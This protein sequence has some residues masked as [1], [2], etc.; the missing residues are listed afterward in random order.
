M[1]R[2]IILLGICIILGHSQTSQDDYVQM[3]IPGY[4]HS[5]YSGYFNFTSKDIHYMYLE[6][7]ND[8]DNDPLV[9]WVSGG[10]G[11]SGIYSM[12]YEIGPFRFLTPENLNLTVTKDAW[13]LRANLLIIETSAIGFSTGSVNSTD[14]SVVND[15]LNSLVEF[16][17]RFPTQKKNNLHL[18]GHGYAGI[19]VPMLAKTIDQRNKLPYFTKIN[20]KGKQNSNCRI[21]VGQSVHHCKRVLCQWF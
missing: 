3:N 5:W 19:I 10:P 6:S 20:L 8:K 16:Y 11:C 14:S 9:L 18:A 15:L 12:Y 4:S 13:N 7:Q 21:F 1:L 2:L 17:A